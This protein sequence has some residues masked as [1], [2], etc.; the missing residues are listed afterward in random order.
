VGDAMVISQIE[1]PTVHRRHLCFEK[2]CARVVKSSGTSVFDSNRHRCGRFARL[3]LD[4]V[5]L[6]T[7]H[8][9]EFALKHLIEKQGG[10]ANGS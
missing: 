9:G 3:E 2:R 10:L 4:G 5:P 6:C 7:Q 1:L 8:A